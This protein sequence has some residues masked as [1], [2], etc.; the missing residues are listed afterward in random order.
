MYL[1]CRGFM[2]N[3]TASLCWSYIED[4][5]SSAVLCCCAWKADDGGGGSEGILTGLRNTHCCLNHVGRGFHRIVHS[6]FYCLCSVHSI[7]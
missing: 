6:G 4:G 1:M 3:T 2:I 7:V 5:I